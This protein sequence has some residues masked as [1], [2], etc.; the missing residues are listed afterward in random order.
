MWIIT[1]ATG[2]IGS[3][4]VWELNQNNVSDLLLSDHV[5]PEERPGL[6]KKRKYTEFIE[7]DKLFEWLKQPANAS[8]VRGVYHMGAC[9]STTE[10]DEAYLQKNNIEYTQTLFEF[11]T[12]ARIPFVYASSGACYGDGKL[13]FDD[14]D[15]SEKFTPL[16]LYGWSKLKFDIWAKKQ[17]KTPPRW[18]GLRFF[19]V[20]G[21][22]EYHKGDM[23]SVAFKAFQQIKDSGTLRLFRSANPKYKDGE[24]LR[25]FVYV[26]DITRWMVEMMSRTDVSSGIYNM[27]YGKARTWLALADNVFQGVGKQININWIEIPENIR[28]QYQYFT[29]AK[30]DRLMAEKLSAPQW[31][32]EKGVKDYVT[33]YLLKQDPYL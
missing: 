25:D 29:E 21:P 16:N 8:K 9:S 12:Q 22:N 23:S 2:F 15:V 30:M 10:T 6:L 5:R 24:Q 18:Y 3:A 33:E 26:K 14:V 17:S 32:L 1:G 27:G 20:Y 4:L 13:G 11:C 7:A 31:S 28:N 19:N